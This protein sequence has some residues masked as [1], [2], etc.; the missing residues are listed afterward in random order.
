MYVT[1]Q[2]NT[3]KPLYM[4]H[5]REGSQSSRMTALSC[6]PTC[7][8]LTPS[9]LNGS[10]TMGNR[11]VN[12]EGLH[13]SAIDVYI[14]R[15]DIRLLVQAQKSMLKGVNSTEKSER[16]QTSESMFKKEW[17]RKGTATQ[18]PTT[19]FWKFW[20]YRKIPKISPEVYIF[21]RPFLRGLFFE[22]LIFRGA[23]L[24]TEIYVSKSI[25]LAL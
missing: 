19:R 7:N 4:R 15:V 1:S 16:N 12:N 20:N 3:E 11:E 18:K 2:M 25:G 23:Y 17:K 21:Q 8:V 22:G 5:S 13:N 24:R 9:N 10:C 14:R 6:S